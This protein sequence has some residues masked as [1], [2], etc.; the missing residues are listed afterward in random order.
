[1]P[2]SI[3]LSTFQKPLL[4]E[5]TVHREIDVPLMFLVNRP[6]FR[7]NVVRIR[8]LMHH[9]KNCWFIIC[10]HRDNTTKWVRN[11]FP[12]LS[13]SLHIYTHHS[14]LI[15]IL[16]VARILPDCLFSY[17]PAVCLFLTYCTCLFGLWLFTWIKCLLGVNS[18]ISN[19]PFSLIGICWTL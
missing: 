3:I 17:V 11:S 18:W 8:G 13:P 16:T 14:P 10:K 5:Q 19:C 12:F 15:I 2:C 4:R 7:Y 9:Y 1:M 6:R